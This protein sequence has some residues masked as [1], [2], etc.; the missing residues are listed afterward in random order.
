MLLKQDFVDPSALRDRAGV[1]ALRLPEEVATEYLG[2]LKERIGYVREVYCREDLDPGVGPQGI[3]GFL[4]L[5][6]R[7]LVVLE[8][9]QQLYQRNVAGSP[10]T[11]DPTGSGFP[12]F[13]EY[14]LLEEERGRAEERL[15]RLPSFGTIVEQARREILA[16]R[17]PCEQQDQWLLRKYLT[18][19][20]SSGCLSQLRIQDPVLYEESERHRHYEIEWYGV[21][22]ASNLPVHFLMAFA[23]DK[24]QRLTDVPRKELPGRLEVEFVRHSSPRKIA[25]SIGEMPDFHPKFVR[26]FTLGS[27][28]TSQT[29]NDGPE[30]ELLSLEADA[31]MLRFATEVSGSIGTEVRQSFLD[32]AL[33]R[34]RESECF[35]PTLLDRRMIVPLALKD[36]LG[37]KDEH[38]EPCKVYGVGEDGELAA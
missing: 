1:N 19:L 26:K 14:V 15:A 23:Q 6:C 20:R 24:R 4:D 7:T 34:R 22:A 37:G 25:A 36:K 18:L 30:G 17:G 8:L 27:Y 29:Q 28:H 5:V 16:A 13:A 12:T 38:G 11:I 31:F 9:R 10:L 3:L 21:E 2:R 32:R 33:R 35:G